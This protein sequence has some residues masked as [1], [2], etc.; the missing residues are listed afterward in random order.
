MPNAHTTLAACAVGTD[1]FVFDGC[2]AVFKY[3]TKTDVWSNLCAMPEPCSRG[4]AS[5]LNGLIYLVGGNDGV[6]IK[7]FAPITHEWSTIAPTLEYRNRALSFVL[8]AHLY[9][10]G[11]GNYRGS[12]ERYDCVT[13]KWTVVEGMIQGRLGFGAVT[14]AIAGPVE[15]QDLFDSLI[16]QAGVHP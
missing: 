2:S 6:G 8:G 13:N 10:L 9:A 4:G 1:I 16:P 14:T 12:M 11:E 15:E 7:R 3:A 5:L